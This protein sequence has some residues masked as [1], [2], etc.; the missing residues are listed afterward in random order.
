[1]AQ[2]YALL[3]PDGS[4][5]MARPRGNDWRISEGLQGVE[6]NGRNVT[7]FLNGFDV[8]GLSAVIPAKNEAQVRRA[9]PFAVEDD[10]ADAVEN[11][12]VALAPPNKQDPTSPRLLNIA[13]IDT[14]K[15]ISDDLSAQGLSEAEIVAAHS[16]LP[17]RDILVEGPG[18]LLGRLGA[19]SFAIDASI[20]RDVVVS[21]LEHHPDVVVQ[22]NHLSQALNR[23]SQGTGAESREALLLQLVEWAETIGPGIN[24]RQGQ[25][26]PSRSL[27]FGGLKHWRFVGGVAAVAVIGWFGALFV[28]T[29][30]MKDR[31]AGLDQLATEFARTGWPET[32]GDVQ[33]VLALSA[34]ERGSSSQS[35]PSLLDA[36]AVL[37]DA[38]A[39]VEGSELRTI[40]YDRLRGQMTASVAFESFAD[41]D[42]LTAI[43]NT[44]GL[45]ARSGD[46]R[47]S[48]S[49]VIGDLTLESPA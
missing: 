4:L 5:L 39:Q 26:A 21:L 47:Q 19:R 1:M 27:E 49:K 12:H 15:E 31:T 45:R 23:P 8:L 20:G 18:L 34:S 44:T 36:S 37:Y 30:A 42:R 24:L 46:S 29:H 7:V 41:V 14:L 28:E 16:V 33:Q 25:F 11:S 2:V 48:G 43:V 40:R 6:A 22:G 17:Q 38:L 35:F 9:A 13:S 32:N 10:L 3:Q